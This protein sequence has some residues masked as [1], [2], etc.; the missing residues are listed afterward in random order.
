MNHKA[1]NFDFRIDKETTIFF[2]EHGLFNDDKLGVIMCR[3]Y[4]D[5]ADWQAVTTDDIE[6]IKGA[7]YKTFEIWLK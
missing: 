2:L 5:D 1:T 7:E 4:G 6:T 3:E